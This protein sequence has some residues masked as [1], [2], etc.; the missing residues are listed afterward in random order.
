M[1]CMKV[2]SRVYWVGKQIQIDGK[3]ILKEIIRFIT[4]IHGDREGQG[5]DVSIQKRCNILQHITKYHN[6][7][8]HITKYYNILQHITKY[9]NLLQHITNS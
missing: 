2:L 7:L 3:I 5:V 6:I 8:Q 9:Y 4:P 1:F